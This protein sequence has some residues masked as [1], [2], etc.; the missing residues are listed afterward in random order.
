MA[1]SVL[2]CRVEHITRQALLHCVI[3]EVK[4]A[5]SE[6]EY[7]LRLSKRCSW[8]AVGGAEMDAVFNYL[9]RKYCDLFDCFCNRACVIDGERG[10]AFSCGA[11]SKAKWTR[12]VEK[13]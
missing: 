3:R 6:G 10:V 12:H 13:R 5:G 9:S 4:V 8:T 2:R 7:K 11:V 1:W